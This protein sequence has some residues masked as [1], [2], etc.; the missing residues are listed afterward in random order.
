MRFFWDLRTT[1]R[2]TTIFSLYNFFSLV[3][4]LLVINITYFFIW[5]NAQKEESLHD[6]DMKYSLFSMPESDME[7]EEFRQYLL[8]RDTLIIP[9]VGD[10][11]CSPWV[12]KK[13][14]ENLSLIQDKYLFHHEWK[15][16]FI[17]SQYYDNIGL[18]KVLFD[19]TPY[20]E[21]QIIITKISIIVIIIFFILTFFISK[22]ISKKAFSS[23]VRMTQEVKNIDIDTKKKIHIPHAPE[24]DEIRVLGEAMN[25]MLHKIHYQTDNLKQFITDVSHE[26]K[27]PLMT[28]NSYI[29]L[30]LKRH[31]K[32]LLGTQDFID[33]MVYFREN[34]KKMNT[35]LETLFYIAR[36]EE[37]IETLDVQDVKVHS[38]FQKKIEEIK[39]IYPEK[40]IQISLSCWK[41]IVYHV[42]PNILSIVVENILTNAVKFAWE[43]E[44]VDI[45]VEKYFF[46]IEDYGVWIDEPKMKHIW[47][48]FYKIDTT[49][50]GFGVG[51]FLVKRLCELCDLDIK[52][53]SEKW[54][55][56]KFCIYLDSQS[57]YENLTDR[58]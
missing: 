58:R 57:S 45:R 48:K 24:N 10:P 25:Q 29:D 13:V 14:H 55:W 51:L 36:V 56:T 4:L 12:E 42:S 17:F 2:I 37:W 39:K 40:N 1:D 54:K 31:E 52:V 27:T 33:N 19:T 3:V 18:V 49:K 44:K 16:Y 47:N 30:Q 22:M 8:E 21:S 41:N 15:T 46:E 23:L 26:F 32:W 38:F 28:M 7:I 35:L 9:E 43:N 11:I 34:I 53:K 6:M 50:E 20:I 5:Y